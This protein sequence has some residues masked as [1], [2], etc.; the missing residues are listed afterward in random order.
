MEIEYKLSKSVREDY[1]SSKDI[2][3]GRLE[4]VE[5]ALP[6]R[7]ELKGHLVDSAP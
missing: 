3:L 5:V 1:A 6:M 2:E 7:R 4:K